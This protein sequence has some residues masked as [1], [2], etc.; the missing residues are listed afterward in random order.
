MYLR[1]EDHLNSVIADQSWS[2]VVHFNPETATTVHEGGAVLKF[3]FG[4]LCP[5]IFSIN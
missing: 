5:I 3:K 4:Y 2:S 1:T